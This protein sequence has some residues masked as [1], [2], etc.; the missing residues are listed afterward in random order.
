M[1]LAHKRVSSLLGEVC[2]AGEVAQEVER[3]RQVW[4]PERVRVVLLAESHVWTSLAE[5]ACRVRSV[6]G[7]PESRYARFVYCL[8]YGEPSLLGSIPSGKNGG[9]PQYWQLFDDCVK[10]PS[11]PSKVLKTNEPNHAKRIQAKIELLQ[12]MKMAGIWLIDASVTAIYRPGIGPIAG[13]SYQRVLEISWDEHVGPLLATCRPEKVV[14]IGRAVGKAIGSRLRELFPRA[15]T[16]A[17][18]SQPNARRSS[19]KLLAWRQSCFDHC[20]SKVP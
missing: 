1:L 5:L 4:R 3:L 15:N 9:T 16:M 18:I 7:L 2:E 11:L 17:V 6:G 12:Q 13:K 20:K 14:V 10:G 8:G 19:S